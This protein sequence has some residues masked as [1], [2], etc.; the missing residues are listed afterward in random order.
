MGIQRSLKAGL[1][2]HRLLVGDAAFCPLT[3]VEVAMESDFG[4]TCKHQH[5]T[6]VLGM[7][8]SPLVLSH[9]GSCSGVRV[10]VDLQKRGTDVQQG[11]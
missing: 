10:G 11:G 6:L 1:R 4:V 3:G 2:R 7:G 8:C 9:T 5:A